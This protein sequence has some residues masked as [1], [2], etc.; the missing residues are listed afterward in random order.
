[1]NYLY[2]A[3]VQGI[4]N[5]I[6][7]TNELKDIVG[8]SEL[9]E[10]IC[11]ER[12]EL[13]LKKHVQGFTSLVDDEN[14]IINAAGNVKYIFTSKEECEKI[15]RVFPKEVVTYA[16][17]VIVSQAVV[18]YE[19]DCEF[20][21]AVD[22][23]E[24]NLRAQRNKPMNSTTMG[25]MGV[26]R[27]RKT[28]L[29]VVETEVID[30]KIEYLDAASL[31]KKNHVEEG[32]KTKK[33]SIT[34][35]V[36]EAFGI[37]NIKPEMLA[38]NIGEM[39]AKNDWVA[40]IH[41]DGNGLGQVVQ[42]IGK[43]KK[44]F[45]DFSN[46]LD[47]ATKAASVEAFNRVE[48]NYDWKII[49]I[50]PIVLGGDDFTVVCRADLALDYVQAFMECFEKYTQFP[51]LEGV[52][53]NNEKKLTS[54]AGIAYVKSS[55]PFYY[56]YELAESLCTRA[57][58]DAKSKMKKVGDMMSL[59]A[60]CLMFHKVQDSFVDSFDDIV[61]RELTPQDAISFEFGPYYIF[62][63]GDYDATRWTVNEL[64]K[65][66][67]LLG[68]K[69]LLD[70]KKGNAV[71]SHLR[72]W[73]SLLHDNPGMADQKRLRM[74]DLLTSNNADDKKLRAF[75]ERVT[76]STKYNFNTPVY[77]ILALHTIYSQ[78]TKIKEEKK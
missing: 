46:K 3:A 24:K 54:C 10:N 76:E 55:Y 73:L 25:M 5:F 8:A 14:A 60:S 30:G 78:Q 68:G 6:F 69:G 37:Q 35:L 53:L 13:L 67:D 39:T 64:K 45:K 2:G 29:P 36:S 49:P 70:E 33:R 74:I 34:K 22:E 20:S 43:D 59:P 32:I 56:G 52:F 71:K 21:L 50:R 31:A 18:T 72:N 63:E 23:L 65:Y 51:E 11:T 19:N 66:A 7:Q 9:V 27:S 16:P 61:E 47:R 75:V 40:V 4:Q 41:V 62:E 44:R 28:N 77:D 12:F 48:K 1:M 26:L 42:K 58:K 57:K 17:G 38:L 15:V